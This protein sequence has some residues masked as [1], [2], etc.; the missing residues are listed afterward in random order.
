MWRKV[1]LGQ[2]LDR[3]IH[4]RGSE[5]DQFL[6]Q[7][8][9]PVEGD[10]QKR[11]V[12]V[13]FDRF[14]RDKVEYAA[15]RHSGALRFHLRKR[16]AA[17]GVERA[18]ADGEATVECDGALRRRKRR[19]AGFLEAR[20]DL[21]RGDGAAARRLG[22]CAG[23]GHAVAVCIFHRQGHRLTGADGAFQCERH[24]PQIFLFIAR[25]NLA[26]PVLG[27]SCVFGPRAKHLASAHAAIVAL[28]EAVAR[29][30]EGELF[31]LVL[32][33]RAMLAQEPRVDLRHGGDVLRALH[34]PLNLEARDAHVHHLRHEGREVR[35]LQ[36]QRM[37]VRPAGKAVGQTAG[38]G[39]GAT[40]A[41]AP[42]DDG[43]HLTLAAVTHA[44]RA[45]DER[46]DLNGAFF[47]DLGN[48]L[49]VQLAREH[50]ARHAEPC[51]FLNARERVQAHL[52]RGVQRH[53]GNDF[54]QRR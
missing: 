1:E 42:P 13:V 12:R 48:F 41:A 28:G 4:P 44:Q 46:F 40:V 14:G 7:L 52:R 43:G 27:P 25:A 9:G 8:L 20:F 30:S 17:Q 45:V 5:C 15:C 33:R 34:A 31:L 29:E 47:A 3:H 36:A 53:V 49:T 18:R 50:R 37:A 38:L 2:Q 10:G 22:H 54:L 24:E 23:D 35:V 26:E 51:R 16:F 11:L 6:T 32:R 21:F 19:A 39:A